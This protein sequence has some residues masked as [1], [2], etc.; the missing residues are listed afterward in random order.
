MGLMLRYSID[1]LSI[2]SKCLSAGGIISCATDTVFGIMCACDDKKAKKRIFAMKNRNV[3]KPLQ[4]L[5]SN[6]DKAQALI[7]LSE[8][9][10]K[11]AQQEWPGAL[12]IVGESK[13]PE[14]DTLAVRV[15]DGPIIELLDVFGMPVAAT[16]AN[17]SGQAPLSDISE[18][19][20]VFGKELDYI[21]DLAYHPNFI[22]PSNKPSK[23]IMDLNGY[24][25]VLREN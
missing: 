25:S 19:A 23:I 17:I 20:A 13:V 21:L 15:P 4:Y 2:I 5:V 22:E 7:K 3:N 24:I 11:I 16:S 12:T 10:I 8:N 1:N 6:F 18:I 9:A 14:F